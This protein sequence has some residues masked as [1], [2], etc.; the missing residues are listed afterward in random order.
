MAPAGRIASTQTAFDLDDLQA[1]AEL[2]RDQRAVG[3]CQV[4]LVDIVA[5]VG[6]DPVDGA[7]GTALSAAARRRV[8]RSAGTRGVTGG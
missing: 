2:D 4:R 3:L 8:R 7:A 6:L 1:L 5:G